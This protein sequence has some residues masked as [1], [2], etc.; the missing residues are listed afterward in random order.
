LQATAKCSSDETVSIC[1]PRHPDHHAV[2]MIIELLNRNEGP[3]FTGIRGRGYAY[4]ASLSCFLWSGMLV[5]E[6]N[7]ASE[8]TKALEA[9]W[10]ILEEWAG[11]GS[12]N[13]S[14]TEKRARWTPSSK[15]DSSPTA[16]NYS[17]FDLDTAR[18]C[19][20]YRVTAGKSTAGGVIS[21]V[22]RHLLRVR[23]CVLANCIICAR[24]YSTC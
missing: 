14:E 19:I 11:V 2:I 16:C 5:F 15:L 8:P 10:G 22:L 20:M 18:A 6:V 4:D 7:D 3:I 13:L 24:F 23:N 12:S 21:S 17:M 9:F 1:D